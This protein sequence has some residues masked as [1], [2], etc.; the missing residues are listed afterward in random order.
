MSYLSV[1]SFYMAGVDAISSSRPLLILT[2]IVGAQNQCTVHGP[3]AES[4]YQLWAEAGNINV[5]YEF[6]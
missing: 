3:S 4:L 6:L 5:L 2:P 1:A